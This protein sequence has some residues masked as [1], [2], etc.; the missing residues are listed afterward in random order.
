MNY[1]LQLLN[2]PTG[3]VATMAPK[4]KV[5]QAESAAGADSGL[6]DDLQSRLD[7]LRKM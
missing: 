3:T 2:A 4:A 6:D 5:A 1:F 7:N